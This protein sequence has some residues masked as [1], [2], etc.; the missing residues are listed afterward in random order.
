MH[1]RAEFPIAPQAIEQFVG[2][3]T[4]KRA[5][6]YVQEGR[7][8][9]IDASRPQAIRATVQGSDQ[10]SVHLFLKLRNNSS[11]YDV[12]VASCTCPV[13]DRCKHIAAVL[14]SLV[15]SSSTDKMEPPDASPQ[16]PTGRNWRE[17]LA[18]MD[19]AR[20]APNPTAAPLG[21]IFQVT[22][23]AERRS[24]D[25]GLKRNVPA[26]QVTRLAV[27]PGLRS[28]KSGKWSTT[29]VSWH[30]FR[31]STCR[32]G[33]GPVIEWF[34]EWLAKYHL[35]EMAQGDSY[36][37]SWYAGPAWCHL[38]NY[39]SANLWK[40]LEDAHARGI[41]F[42]H[43]IRDGVVDMDSNPIS[44]SLELSA[45]AHSSLLFAPV[46]HRDHAPLEDFVIHP[47]GSPAVGAYCYPKDE[48]E[49]PLHIM[50]APLREELPAPVASGIFGEEPII[51]PS[52]DRTAFLA[53]VY[54]TLASHVEIVSSTPALLPQ[55]GTPRLA[56]SVQKSGTHSLELSFA[57][58]YYLDSNRTVQVPVDVHAE[59]P[60]PVLRSPQDELRITQLVLPLLEQHIPR[61][62]QIPLRKEWIEGLGAAA[63]LERTLP[64]LQQLTDE[65]DLIMPT[66]L[67]AFHEAV[68]SPTVR[69]HAQDSTEGDWLD[70]GIE[71][72]VDGKTVPISELIR[73]LSLNEPYV[74]L[75]DGTYF[76]SNSPELERLRSLLEESRLL[77]DTPSGK[78]RVNRFQI[79]FWNELENLGI[80]EAQ[81]SE[82]LTCAR[83]LQSIT[84]LPECV[85]PD[86]FGATLRPYQNEGFRWLSFLHEHGLGC[87][88]A[89]D[90]G[91]GKTVQA[92]AMLLRIHGA[93][94][95][96]HPSLIIAPTSVA[97]NWLHECARFA[98]EL[99]VMLIEE[100]DRKAGIPIAERIAG[101]DLVISTYTLLRIDDAAYTTLSWEAVILDEAQFLKNHHTKGY[102]TARLLRARAR[103][104]LTGTP[105]EN[106]LMEL[107]SI[108]S[109]VA[110]G[111]LGHPARFQDEYRTPIETEHDGTALTKLRRRIHPLVLRRTKDQVVQDLPAKS[112]QVIELELND[113]HRHVYDLHLQ[114]ERLKV[115]GLLDH[116]EDH[117]ISILQSLTKLRQLSL[118]PSLIDERQYSS[119]PSTKLD[120]LGEHLQEVVEE[121][122]T[123]LVFSQFTRFL[124]QV[125]TRLEELGIPYLYLD[126]KTRNRGALL[127]T[128]ATGTTP[129]F[130]ISLKAGGFGLN[131]AEADY[132]YLLDPWWNPAVEQQAIDRIHRIGQTRPVMVYRLVALNTIEEKVLELSGRKAEL[133]ASVL[134]EGSVSD[135]AITA[136]DIRQLFD[137]DE[138]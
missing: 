53:R 77:N 113:R 6:A 8:V 16:E 134:D 135:T 107:W 23:V 24:W 10:Y 79:D 28:A 96:P 130:L 52:F 63:F 71:L 33:S 124:A 89:D 138:E 34:Q 92:L 118:S 102:R 54:P 98:P 17:A 119:I 66:P 20:T 109:I 9:S 101:C 70:L 80:V 103:H 129:V 65:V 125:R 72:T 18:A 21:L 91:L 50:L 32:H 108:L 55:R 19:T 15:Q 68:T 117:R 49:K 123:A 14:L 78:Y 74:F 51:V 56:I 114:Q 12:Y 110:P 39:R 95:A 76:P 99:K 67:P 42:L 44:V 41:P 97:A 64:E 13:G 61:G 40:Q 57:W 36:V 111:L 112:E 22:T 121:G 84:T 60:E 38:D 131:L 30:D 26:P 4:Y 73:A 100:T 85:V 105:L 137:T 69:I 29:G 48:T 3:I 35:S 11:A 59:M 1:A 75:E 43:A 7:V 82:W 127:D 115:L 133:F 27:R 47:F 128:F 2:S 120:A 106:N 31:Y 104:A 90:M 45:T 132:C 5:V 88:L 25:R 58:N 87:I 126:G 122:H 94:T 46:F 81:A 136:E 116:Y 86:G 37:S 62:V 93:H 83:R